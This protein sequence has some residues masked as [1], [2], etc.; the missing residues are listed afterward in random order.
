MVTGAY[1]PEMSGAGLQCDTLV[2]G[3]QRDVD[4]HVLTTTTDPGLAAED[5]RAGT[6]VHRVFIDPRSVWS[7]VHAAVH[8]LRLFVRLAPRIAVVHLH[9]FSQKSIL[10]VLLARLSR[11]RIVIKLTSFGDDDPV[12]MR[13]RGRLANWAFRQAAIFVAVSPRFRPSYLAAGLPV[14]RLREIP[15]GVDLQRFRPPAPGER[16]HLRAQLGLPVDARITLFVGFFSSEKRPHLLFD[17]WSALALHDPRRLLLFVG[18]TRSTYFE[19]DRHLAA[20]I[21]DRATA[22]GL[23][24]RLS[25]VEHTSEIERYYRAAD[26]FV[27]PSVRE[28][29]PNAL[30]EAMATGLP[31]VATRLDGVTT[32]VID[33]GRNGVL[34]APDASDEIVTA[35][36]AFATDPP[37]AAA[38]GIEARRTIEMRYSLQQ[39]AREYLRVYRELTGGQPCAV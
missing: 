32:G 36:E 3:L 38:V 33:D 12:S 22:A 14:T 15:N 1:Y 13:R 7:R 27:L 24:R 6:P 10:L 18:A 35:L 29:L 21:R 31:C 4:F 28:G 11:K 20:R 23:D 34:V 19:V 26:E 9:G 39:V 8:V 5:D 25:F 37:R 2:R 30:L 16:E 17:A